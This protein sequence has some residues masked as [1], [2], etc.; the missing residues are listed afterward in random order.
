MGENIRFV[1][2]LGGELIAEFD[3]SS[4]NLKKEY[5]S[6]GITIEPTAVNSNG[7]QYG[8]ADRLGTAR[9][10]T[11][12]SGSIVSRHDYMPFGEELGAGTGGR[13]TGI[14]FS[15][16]G[17]NNRMKF[18]GDERDNET[19]LDF[20]QARY[21]SG[22]LGRFT[23]P[24]PYSGSISTASPQSFNRYAFV[25]NNPVNRTD[26]SG[27]DWTSDASQQ[28]CSSRYL[29]SIGSGW[30]IL[31]SK[32]G[33]GWDSEAFAELDYIR[34]Q[35][36]AA[37]TVTAVV[38]DGLSKAMAEFWAVADPLGLSPENPQ[39][40][41]SAGT[42]LIV[43]GD[44]GLGP[45][46]QGP[47][48]D[49]AAETKRQ[50]LKA[51]GYNAIVRRA[52]GLDDVNRELTGNGMLAGVE[53]VGHAS[54][55]ALYVGEQPGAGTNIDLSNVSQLSKGNL[56][57]NAYIK[58]N[59]CYTG[60]GGWRNSIAGAMAN[61]LGRPVFAFNGPTKFYGSSNAVRGSGG[62]Y[63]PPTGPLYLME[64]LGTRLV[65]YKP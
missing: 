30:S 45:H 21:N 19:G 6:D 9:V 49:R 12:S 11:N 47:N 60:L 40:A 34:E 58:I 14:G 42:I 13:T 10:L 3:G 48:F 36:E 41:G 28:G 15:N 63:P 22:T 55:N 20:A 57:P 17:D 65:V 16:S 64:D 35:E 50:E 26:P 18:T 8:T 25:G 33:G 59:A 4:G 54:E 52:S 56:S 53:Y 46:N 38:D 37:V 23:T 51:S 1:Y 7:A 24:D 29:A 44:P 43:V 61:H 62:N 5:I 31:N 2:G 39:N 32:V 27:L